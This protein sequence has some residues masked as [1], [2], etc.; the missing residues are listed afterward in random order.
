[1][2]ALPVDAAVDAVRAGAMPV[3][4]AVALAAG[5]VSFASPCV[6]PLVPGFLGYVTGLS[7]EPLERQRRGRLVTGAL[8]FVAGF[9]A[10][11]VAV[12]AATASAL[13]LF[14]REHQSL[15]T[16]TGGVV[17]IAL[18]LVFLGFG[19]QRKKGPSWRPRAGLAGAPMLGVV[20]GL[21]LTP[22]IGPTFG[23]IL[24]LLVPLSTDAA[25]GVTRGVALATAYSLGLGVPFLLVASGWNRASRLSGWL[26]AHQRGI[27]RFGGGL[28]LAVGALMVSGLWDAVMAGLQTRLVNGFTTVL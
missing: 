6:L 13:G 5:L 26:R 23:A 16:R 20:F 11:F 8:L 9:T 18:A 2:T 25:G 19:P 21:S 27:Q 12:T 28:L 7:G 4:V 24:A 10:V 17:V 22:C 3:A 14:V 1:M 15:L